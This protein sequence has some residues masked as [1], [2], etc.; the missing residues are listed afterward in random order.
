MPNG[1]SD[2]CGNCAYNSA[3]KKSYFPFLQ[4]LKM[5]FSIPHCIVHD[6][7]IPNQFWTYCQNFTHKFNNKNL[8]LNKKEKIYIFTNGLYE[9]NY[10][11]VP[12]NGRHEPRISVSALC[13][14]CKKNTQ[15]GILV[16]HKG[17]EIGFC[18]NQHYIQWWNSVHI[19]E[20]INSDHC[21]S[22]DDE[23]SSD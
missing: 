16:E 6:V 5:Y 18:S 13:K 9:E 23:N 1:G 2:C 17:K 12:W 20:S 14:I 11:R 8:I 15:K 3:V 7:A 22:P 19:D 21:G 10:V 4:I